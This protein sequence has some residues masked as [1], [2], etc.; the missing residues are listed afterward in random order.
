[1][2]ELARVRL[3]T[4]GWFLLF[5]L[6]F[7]GWLP[8][9]LSRH[10][11]GP[12]VWLGTLRQWLGAWLIADGSALTAWCVNLFNVQGRGTPLPLDPPKQFV[13]AGPYR[14]VR[15]PMMLGLFL[16]LG[17]QALLYGS[18]AVLLYLVLVMGLAH[19]FIALVEEPQLKR[20]FGASYEAY[21]RQVPRWLPRLPSK[22]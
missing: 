6:T 20:R 22:G 18:R 13:V 2:T 15:N 4:L 14:V 17:G 5:P 12:F 9:G 7:I 10:V 3:R 11:D 16:L 1:M 8:W 21:R 19:L